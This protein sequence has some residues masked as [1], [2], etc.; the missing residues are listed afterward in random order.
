M[1]CYA[2]WSLPHAGCR[3]PSEVATPDRTLGLVALGKSTH[4][5]VVSSCEIIATFRFPFYASVKMTSRRYPRPA[6]TKAS[7]ATGTVML[8]TG[9][10]VSLPGLDPR[11]P[12]V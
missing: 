9:L 6:H 12:Y 4:F 8:S 11:H 7:L 5:A 10:S 1:G 2:D 3:S